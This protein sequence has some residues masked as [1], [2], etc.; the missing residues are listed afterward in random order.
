MAT[1]E[2]CSISSP[3]TPHVHVGMI[4]FSTKFEA[5]GGP[6]VL[7]ISTVFRTF[8]CSSVIT[9]TGY[10]RS[11]IPEKVLDCPLTNFERSFAEINFEGVQA[12]WMLCFKPIQSSPEV[13]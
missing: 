8:E 1:E 3:H 10:L 7:D 5:M 9:S 12:Y 4:Y 2:L 13:Y 6:I 11:N